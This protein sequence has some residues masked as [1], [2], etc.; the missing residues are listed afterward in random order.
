MWMPK[1]GFKVVSIHEDRY[2]QIINLANCLGLSI[3]K[4]IETAIEVYS[5]SDEFQSRLNQVIKER[6]Q[7]LDRLKSLR[8]E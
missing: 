4:L 6:Q 7:E 3:A 8:K 2:Q 1:K 5:K